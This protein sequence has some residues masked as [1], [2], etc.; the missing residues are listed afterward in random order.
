M[1]KLIIAV[2]ALAS[3]TTMSSVPASAACSMW[4]GTQMKCSTSVP[5]PFDYSTSQRPSTLP[6]PR[7]TMRVV[8]INPTRT[9]WVCN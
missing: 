9:E 6:A 2:A 7:C 1:K 4:S 3:L 8:S 5:K